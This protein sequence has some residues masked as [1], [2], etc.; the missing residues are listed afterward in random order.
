[1]DYKT[2]K[3][4]GISGGV[5]AVIGSIIFT[6]LTTQIPLLSLILGLAFLYISI[7]M[8]YEGLI[9]RGIA[10]KA[11]QEVPGGALAKS[12]IGIGIGILAGV[13][14]LSGGYA[15]VPSFIYILGAPVKIAVGTGLPSF[16]SMA[17]VSGGFKLH[18]GY[19]DL[20]AAVLLGAGTALGAQ[21]GAG[22][23]PRAPTWLTKSAFGFVFLYVSLK[24]IL[25]IFGIRI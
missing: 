19:A 6:Y 25:T 4:V 11:G 24:F 5:C 17:V 2:V 14:G 9:R 22:L 16:I 8:I 12:L 10:E 1:V 13:V 23:V 20:V 18:Q 15:L 21:L 7:R 3:I